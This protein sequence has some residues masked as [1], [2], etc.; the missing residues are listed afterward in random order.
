MIPEEWIISENLRI[1]INA[2]K[3]VHLHFF[4]CINVYWILVGFTVVPDVLKVL[5]KQYKSLTD[6]WDIE[7]CLLKSIVC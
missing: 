1:K 4:V 3:Q 2:M 6:I 5:K 7:N